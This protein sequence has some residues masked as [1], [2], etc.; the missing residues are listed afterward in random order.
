MSRGSAKR[1]LPRSLE[2]TH[3]QPTS[4][5]SAALDGALTRSQQ[6][7]LCLWVAM[8]LSANEGLLE[9]IAFAAIDII[10]ILC[11]RLMTTPGSGR[12]ATISTDVFK[13]LLLGL[14]AVFGMVRQFDVRNIVYGRI[15]HVPYLMLPLKPEYDTFYTVV[16]VYGCLHATSIGKID[17]TRPVRDATHAPRQPLSTQPHLDNPFNQ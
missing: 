9:A 17:E 4:K 15:K 14:L 10:F 8:L 5:L 13:T 6:A 2:Q 11:T 1:S 16:P 12:D 3:F 7:C